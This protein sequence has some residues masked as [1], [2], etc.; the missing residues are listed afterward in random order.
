[1]TDGAQDVRGFPAF[2]AGARRRARFARSWWGN[3]WITAIEDAALDSEQM[4]IGRKYAYAGQVGPITV[5][6]GRIAATVYGSDRTPHTT[7]VHITQL[8]D[9]EWTRLLDWVA[10]KSGYIAALLDKDMPHDLTAAEIPILPQMTDLEPDCDCEGW[11]LPCR[12]AAALSYQV[13][14]LL[15]EDPFVLLLIRGRGEQHLL[16]ELQLRNGPPSSMLRYLVTDAAARAQALL[17]GKHPQEL[18]E[19]QD[20]VRWAATYPALVGQ[21]A[22]ATGRDLTHAVRAWTYGGLTGLEVLETT[23]RPSKTDLAKAAAALS[24]E[25]IPSLEQARNHWTAADTQLRLGRDGRWYP[26]RRQDGEW[27]PAG[28]PETDPAT[29][30]LAI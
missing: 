28:P 11:E 20:A 4:K 27:L 5:S 19:W 29:A 2:P 13:A 18:T 10:A 6:P 30:L 21:L 16:D 25:D 23:W 14:W 3:A 1:M 26:Y 7:T 12:H 8:T 9:A 17:D 22:E 15:D 24:A